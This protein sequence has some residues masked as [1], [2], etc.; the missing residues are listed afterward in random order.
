MP[1]RQQL[2][3]SGL[4]LTLKDLGAVG[5]ILVAA[6]TGFT[7]IASNMYATPNQVQRELKDHARSL[8]RELDDK[9]STSEIKGLRHQIS[10]LKGRVETLSAKVDTAQAV[11]NSNAKDIAHSAE[12]IERID[13][14]VEKLVRRL[15]APE[16]AP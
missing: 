12:K 4:T 16:I 14:N 15:T 11:A 8:Q 10:E 7:T 1:S 9:A 2:P 13:R 3:V 6:L 5:G